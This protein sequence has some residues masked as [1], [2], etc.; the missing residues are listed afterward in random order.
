MFSK[1]SKF[2]S[3]GSSHWGVP[4]QV[5]TI[6]LPSC[7]IWRFTFES[8]YIS[9]TH[10]EGFGFHTNSL[11][12]FPRRGR[13]QC[14]VNFVKAVHN[15]SILYQPLNAFSNFELCI[16]SLQNSRLHAT[17]VKLF[18]SCFVWMRRS[19]IFEDNSPYHSL[20]NSRIT[21][22]IHFVQFQN[23]VCSR[24]PN[25]FRKGLREV[26]VERLICVI[27]WG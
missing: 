15:L 8:A 25:R 16:L 5:P 3:K 4:N 19:L 11:L 17:Y 14:R 23:T 6:S 7:W 21:M 10:P 18:P 12:L 22:Y 2:R 27:R 1:F 26:I 20:P 13:S 24:G 9:W